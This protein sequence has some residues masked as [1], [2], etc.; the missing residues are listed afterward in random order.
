MPKAQFEARAANV[1]TPISMALSLAQIS[2]FNFESTIPDI[3]THIQMW[4]P[5]V[6]KAARS[7]VANDRYQAFF[8]AALRMAASTKSLKGFS[9]PNLAKKAGYSRSTFFRLFEGYSGFLIQGYQLTCLLSVK[10]YEDQLRNRPMTLE[11]FS[12]FTADIFYSANCTVPNEVCTML[13]KEHGKSHA[14]FHPHLSLIGPIVT[15]YLQKTPPLRRCNWMLTSWKAQS[16]CWIWIS[17]K[18]GWTPK[19]PFPAASNISGC[20]KCFW[21]RYWPCSTLRRST[22]P[23]PRGQCRSRASR[24]RALQKRPIGKRRTAPA[25]Q[26]QTM[27]CGQPK[28][29]IL[30]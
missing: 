29:H 11:A 17:C 15:D 12:K 9:V 21:A 4:L 8:L 7:F 16:K 27:L 10:V 30:R 22:T 2:E 19:K 5:E 18:R 23:G 26:V 20:I 3:D 14:E 25:W 13:W 24:L 1:G 6:E 28:W